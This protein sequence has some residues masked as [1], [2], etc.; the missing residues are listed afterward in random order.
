M[1]LKTYTVSRK[2]DE[3]TV[4]ARWLNKFR[5]HAETTVGFGEPSELKTNDTLIH[6]DVKDVHGVLFGIAAIA[7]DMGWRPQGLLETTMEH[8]RGYRISGTK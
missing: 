6:G 8:I 3:V 2:G 4:S 5:R 1:K 7:W